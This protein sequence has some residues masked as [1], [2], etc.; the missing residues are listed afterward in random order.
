MSQNTADTQPN[1]YQENRMSPFDMFALKELLQS[2]NRDN[3][4]CL[5]IG[6]WFG[7]GSTQIIGNFCKELVCVDHWQGNENDEHREIVKTIDVFNR[8]LHN[9]SHFGDKIKPIRG[10]SQDVCPLLEKNKYDF[11][12]IDGDHRYEATVSDI[13]STI[14]L[15]KPGGILAG[16]DCEGRVTFETQNLINRYKDQDHIDSI[17]PNFL[18]CHPGV[19]KAVDE[20][21][22]VA[23]LYAEKPLTVDGQN[24]VSTIWW[25]KI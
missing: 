12:F 15:L 11:I 4:T 18:H 23:N 14:S 1:S 24:G 9:T 5:E 21:I 6:S 16:H 3:L 8:F 20:L 22:D 13:R 7:A 10:T 17:Y 19:I 25:T 2:F